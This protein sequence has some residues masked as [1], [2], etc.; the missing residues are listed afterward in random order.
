SVRIAEELHTALRN[1]GVQAPYIL[2][3]SAFGSYNVRTFADE[4]MDDVAG[5]VLVDGDATDLEPTALQEEDHRGFARGVKGLREC[6]DAVTSGKPLPL[7]PPRPGQP[8]RTCAQQF[9]R[10]LP[11]PEWSPELN[12][13]LLD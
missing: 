13:K 4:Y 7:L 9:Y 2:V 3:G 1:A 8:H 6:R 10:G 11:E 5:L 12:A